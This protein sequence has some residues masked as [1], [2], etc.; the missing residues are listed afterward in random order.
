MALGHH[1]GDSTPGLLL[2]FGFRVRVKVTIMGLP[3]SPPI[4]KNHMEKKMENETN[5]EAM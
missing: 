5:A 2:R 1:L 3:Y 4:M